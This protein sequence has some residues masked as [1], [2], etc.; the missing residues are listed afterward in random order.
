VSA[1]ENYERLLNTL[2]QQE[3][4]LQFRR[5]DNDTAL[6]LGL[7][8]VEVA[9][10]EHKA[11]TVDIGRN[12]QQ[13]FH[14]ALAGTAPDNDEWLRRKSNVVTRFGHS[15]YYMGTHYRARGTTFEETARVDPNDYAAHGG[16]FPVIVKGVGVVGTVAVS[17]LPQIED[18]ELLVGVL[19]EFLRSEQE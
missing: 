1:L 4:E 7:R 8:I 9:K 18:H 12:G 6:Q 13:L 14:C 11:V 17:G 2:R 19:R 16:A 5:F 3:E 15:S 10:R